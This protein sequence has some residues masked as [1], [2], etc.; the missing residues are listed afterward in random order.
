[1]LAAAMPPLLAEISAHDL[2]MAETLIGVAR[3]ALIFVA[4]RLLAEAGQHH[5]DAQDRHGCC[6][7]GW[8]ALQ[9]CQLES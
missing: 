3:F 9:W 6:S 4:A 7:F 1:M 2:E 5:R 8:E